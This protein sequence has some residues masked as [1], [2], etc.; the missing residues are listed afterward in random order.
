MYSSVTSFCKRDTRASDEELKQS[1]DEKWLPL[2]NLKKK[3]LKKKKTNKILK[4][5]IKY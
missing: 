1:D 4:Y 2:L 5:I 3:N